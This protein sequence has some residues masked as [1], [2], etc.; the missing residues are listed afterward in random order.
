M[1]IVE[2]KVDS[3]GNGR[4]DIGRELKRRGKVLR[5]KTSA[6]EGKLVRRLGKIATCAVDEVNVPNTARLSH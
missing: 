3:V 6:A 1:K 4:E 2:G 5:G